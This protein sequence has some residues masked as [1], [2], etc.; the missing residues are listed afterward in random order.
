MANPNSLSDLP[1]RRRGAATGRAT[2]LLAVLVGGLAAI[3][4]STA[5]AQGFATQV[6]SSPPAV[7]VNLDVLS[8]LGRPGGI[9]VTVIG[10]VPF[11]PPFPPRRPFRATVPPPTLASISPVPPPVAA[12]SASGV[13][14]P[15]LSLP[16]NPQVAA[17]PT[18]Q[19]VTPRLSSEP[20]TPLVPAAADLRPGP[21]PPPQTSA[22]PPRAIE[23][24]PTPLAPTEAVAV[25]RAEP[26][27]PS[28]PASAPTPAPA[29]APTPTPAAPPDLSIAPSPSPAA[30]PATE[31]PSAAPP[32]AP[33]LA[34]RPT[35]PAILAPEPAPAVPAAVVDRPPQPTA[36]ADQPQLQP[37]PRL[38]AAPAALPPGESITTL[39]DGGYRI[40]FAVGSDRL[41]DP[42]GQLLSG[43][44][45]RM[46]NN[47][48]DRLQ[49]RAYAD[50]SDIQ[51]SEARRL[52]L[53][54]A[55][56]VRTFLVD[57]G[58]AGTR[59]DVRALGAGADEPPFDRVD[60]L[61]SS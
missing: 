20:A 37:G 59:I 24:P 55:L 3:P 1:R 40:L 19:P 43:L 58:V 53:S 10:D 44:S 25:P 29:P 27:L 7:E 42:A 15:E 45:E 54:R 30:P 35:E 21:V 14:A 60:V 51:P 36:G 4:P 56:T 13:P 34:L 48:A 8:A 28:Q 61:F 39:P 57:R 9:G 33:Q 23:A 49:I 11:V 31:P 22:A 5:T 50:G 26:T 18:P 12:P 32:A 2:I 38:S 6:S 52:S 41:T 17:R 46:I 47:P 16:S